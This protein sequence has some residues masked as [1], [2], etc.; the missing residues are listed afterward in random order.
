MVLN[1]ADATAL[2][3]NCKIKALVNN[4]RRKH[5]LTEPSLISDLQVGNINTNL[6]QH[7]LLFD[8][9]SN[10]ARIQIFCTIKD[11]ERI[12]V[13][14]EIMCDGTFNVVLNILL[15]YIRLYQKNM[16]SVFHLYT[17]Y[18]KI[19]VKKRTR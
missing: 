13:A 6:G 1:N 16:A 10:E 2:Q 17:V 4:K 11:V 14:E 5:K 19:N 18:A 7:F 15:N 8:N 3:S 9:E 12:M